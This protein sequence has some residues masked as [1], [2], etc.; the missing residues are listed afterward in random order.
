MSTGSEASLS[1]GGPFGP[2]SSSN[3]NGILIPDMEHG[4]KNR[5]SVTAFSLIAHSLPV[6]REESLYSTDELSSYK[7][8]PKLCGKQ[9]AVTSPSTVWV[10]APEVTD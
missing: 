1:S 3:T 5:V 6:S 9:A 2:K 8:S 4:D 7:L 10:L